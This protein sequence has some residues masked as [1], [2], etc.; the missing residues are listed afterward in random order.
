MVELL[1]VH[2][3]QHAV[4]LRIIAVILPLPV[5]ESLCVCLCVCVCVCVCGVV[6]VY[7]V[8][9]SACLIFGYAQKNQLILLEN[10]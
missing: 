7:V 3:Q 8:P 6:G 10:I 1:M 9:V 5:F 2:Q 4:L